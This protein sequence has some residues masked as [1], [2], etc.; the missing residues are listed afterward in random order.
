MVYNIYF[1]AIVLLKVNSDY[2]APT[3]FNH[4]TPH[5]WI[6]GTIIPLYPFYCDVQYVIIVLSPYYVLIFSTSKDKW[7]TIIRHF[8]IHFVLGFWWKNLGYYSVQQS[9]IY[10]FA[11]WWRYDCIFWGFLW[12]GP[13]LHKDG[14]MVEKYVPMFLQFNCFVCTFHNYVW[15]LVWICSSVSVKLVQI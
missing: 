2:I 15:W 5:L 1:K 8:L 10:D 4:T 3:P 13:G 6:K 14:D 7:Y 9:H 12:K 11:Y